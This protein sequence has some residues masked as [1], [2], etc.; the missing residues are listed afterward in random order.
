MHACCCLC[1]CSPPLYKA[2][3][4]SQ[5][6]YD[7][8][9]VVSATQEASEAGIEIIRQGGNAVDAAVAVKFALAVTFPAAGNLGGGRI[10][11]ASQ[12]RW[13][14]THPGFPGNGA[15]GGPPRYVSG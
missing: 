11:G 2:R 4:G 9:A 1:C 13:E 14:C 6:I 7:N 3:S 5:K 12:C 8:A 15:L 10:S